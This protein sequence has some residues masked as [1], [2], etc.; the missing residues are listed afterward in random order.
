MFFSLKRQLRFGL[1]LLCSLGLSLWL[2]GTLGGQVLAQSPA[3]DAQPR[4]IQAPNAASGGESGSSGERRNRE[5]LSDGGTTPQLDAEAAELTPTSDNQYILE[6]NRSPIVGS[7]LRLEGIYNESRLRFT[8]PRNWQLDTVK[9][10]LRY[11]HSAALYA[12]RSNLNVLV[13]GSNVGSVPLNK[14]QG[15]TGTVI[16]EIPTRIIQDYNEVIIAGLQ[17]NSP[18]CTQDPFD[19]S[20]WTEILPDSKLVFDYNQAP[21][22][23]DFNAYPYPLID[24]LSLEPNRLDYLVPGRP[25]QAWLT[26]AAQMQTA[27]GRIADY[28]PLQVNQIQSIDEVEA[29][30]KVIVIGTPSQQS[31][32]ATLPLPLKLRNNKILDAQ[33]RVIDDATG[34]LMWTVLDETGVPILVATG[35]GPVG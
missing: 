11:R 23:L 27:V 5:P 28:R 24:V 12:T 4:Q 33:Q 18:T 15:E 35:N 26:A 32:I 10:L 14:K 8:R 7:R 34:V 1:L 17:N 13:N 2:S 16:F 3:P 6:F 9:I 20:L 30:E 21:F 25:D 29:G 19:P 22:P 31:V